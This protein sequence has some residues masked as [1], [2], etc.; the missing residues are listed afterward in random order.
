MPKR[1]HNE[2]W[3][4][5]LRD[6]IKGS[7]GRGWTVQEKNGQVRLNVRR[8]GLQGSVVL[9]FPW[10]RSATGDIQARIR[11]IFALVQEGRSLKEAA[12]VAAR[13]APKAGGCDWQEA[14][15]GFEKEKRIHG[16][17]ITEKAW[18]DNYQP[19][20]GYAVAT[21]ASRNPP[22]SAFE[23]GRLVIERW[24][25]KSRSRQIAVNSL[26][27]FL[28]FCI[29]EYGLNPA[30]WT[31][32]HK[33]KKM[34]KGKAP[35]KREKAILS[36]SDLLDLLS[37]LGD[38]PEALLWKKR[39]QLMIMYGLRPE[40]LH[41]L[42]L[43]PHPRLHKLLAYC[44]YEKPSGEYR[45]KPRWLDPCLP[46]GASWSEPDL[47]IGEFCNDAIHK[48]LSRQMLWRKYKASCE[49]KGL[50]LR[51][52]VFRDSY[53]FRCHQQGRPLNRI[54]LAMGHSLMTHQKHYVWAQD[55]TILDAISLST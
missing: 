7:C 46:A 13:A 26:A 11:N 3:V 25:D 12:L 33:Q 15:I 51:P 52:Y 42:E 23:L 2:L 49:T 19:F 17:R 30:S 44:T 10:E 16:N 20:L 21:M 18:K 6:A 53:S 40:E 35:A 39:L 50:W 45:T 55:S 29:E 1:V 38:R 41:H 28:E 5:G 37:S 14:L 47:K 27:G 43:R 48:F 32:T 4:D 22:G 31:F 54:C 24:H 9:P 36:D 34:L 8:E